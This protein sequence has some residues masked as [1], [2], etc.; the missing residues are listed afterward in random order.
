MKKFMLFCLVLV[1]ALSVV[2]CSTE[3]NNSDYLPKI[4][5]EGALYRLITEEPTMEVDESAIIGYT[6]SY[7]DTVPK[8]DNE[9]NFN[10]E[11]N[12]PIAK[13]E[14]GIAVFYNNEWY[15]CTPVY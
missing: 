6:K 9:T 13:V 15:F 3:E 11:L 7:T 4:M 1:F 12:M 2:G 5:V 10:R 14:G 8:K